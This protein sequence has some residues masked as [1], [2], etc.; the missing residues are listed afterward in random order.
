[1]SENDAISKDWDPETSDD[2][3]DPD[4]APELG[5]HFF[6]HA[7]IMHGDKVIREA[8]GT[9]TRVFGRP[10]SPDPKQLVSIRLDRVVLERLRASGAGWQTRVNDILRKAVDA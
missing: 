1:M 2:S 4:T 9:L 10:K 3:W 5:E 7:A 6:R 8:T